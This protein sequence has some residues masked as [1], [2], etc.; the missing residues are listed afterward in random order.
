VFESETGR[1]AAS[2]DEVAA[3]KK[4][5]KS[6]TIRYGAPK[7]AVPA[8]AWEEAVDPSSGATYWRNTVTGAFSWHQQPAHADDDDDAPQPLGGEEAAGGAALSSGL[9]PTLRARMAKKKEPSLSSHLAPYDEP[10]VE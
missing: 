8:D 4:R 6:F 5:K 7:D 1:A 10:D 9:Q 2:R 3:A